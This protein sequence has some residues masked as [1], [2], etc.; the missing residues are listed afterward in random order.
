[1]FGVWGLGFRVWGMGFGVGVWGCGW[2]VGGMYVHTLVKNSL[3]KFLV[4]LFL[5]AK[6]CKFDSC[7]LGHWLLKCFPDKQPGLWTHFIS[8][9]QY[10]LRAYQWPEM[11]LAFWAFTFV[12]KYSSKSQH[13]NMKK[14]RHFLLLSNIFLL[15]WKPL[16]TFSISHTGID[17]KGPE[18]A[19]ST[20]WDN[21]H[22]VI[23]R[24]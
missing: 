10:A 1:M 7:H 6:V 16:I 24:M 17:W 15:S 14:G 5:V 9:L 18:K 13:Q 4:M 3:I 19:S 21:S 22:I 23:E 20:I 2:W 8:A 12:L 11:F